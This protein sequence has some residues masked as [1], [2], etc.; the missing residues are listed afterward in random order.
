MITLYSEFRAV[1]ARGTGEVM[2]PSRF[3]RSVNQSTRVADYAHSITTCP[4][5]FSDFPTALQIID[6]NTFL[7]ILSIF[8]WH[9]DRKIVVFN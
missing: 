2:S 4:P 3:D 6:D 1:G 7:T 9:P 8:S 5:G